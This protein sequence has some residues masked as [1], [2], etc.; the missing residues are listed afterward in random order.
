MPTSQYGD[1]LYGS[2][3]FGLRKELRDVDSWSGKFDSNVIAITDLYVSVGSHVKSSSSTSSRSSIDFEDRTPSSFADVFTTDSMTIIDLSQEV[4]SHSD[5]IRSY[6][7]NERTS[8]ELVDRGVYWDD[9]KA[10]WYTDWFTENRLTGR[11]DKLAIRSLVVKNAKE[12][13]ATVVVEYDSD[14]D[15][16]V[17]ETSD[18]IELERNQMV[19]EITGIPIDPE[20]HYRLRI[21]EY[22]GYNSLYAIDTAIVH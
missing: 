20:A 7:Y 14:G 21:M 3:E 11:E 2:S 12:P 16:K 17:D 1:F 15:G 18:K 4:S 5:Q 6:I 22:S 13:A 8:L 19:E 9:D 10:E